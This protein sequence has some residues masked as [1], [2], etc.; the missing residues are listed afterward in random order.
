MGDGPESGDQWGTVASVVTRAKAMALTWEAV[1]TLS[2]NGLE[3]TL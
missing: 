1:G 3:R 2:D